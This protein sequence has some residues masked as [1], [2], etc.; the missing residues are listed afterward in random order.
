[1]IRRGKN[2][3]NSFLRIEWSLV[4]KPWVSSPK[5]AL[6]PV[7]LK[8]APWFCRRFFKFRECNFATSRLSPLGKGCGPPF[9][10]NRILSPKMLCA[11][12]GW[13]WL[14]GSG[15][16]DFLISSTHFRYFVIISLW[17]RVG[18]FIWRNLN[19]FYVTMFVQRM[20]EIGYAV[21]E[22]FRQHLH[23]FAIS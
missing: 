21:L 5:D 19:P 16:E 17:K 9:E 1:M 3:F 15:E 7:W 18:P 13:Y 23:I 11:K 6:C 14:S 20:V 22:K 12:I 8:L 4:V 10:Q 2:P